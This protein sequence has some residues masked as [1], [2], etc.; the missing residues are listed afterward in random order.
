[1]RIYRARQMVERDGDGLLGF[2]SRFISAICRKDHPVSIAALST[3]RGNGKSWLA[4]YLVAKSITPGDP[5]HE[6]GIEN[7]LVASSRQ[8]AA[9][10]LNF[11]RNF[12]GEEEGYRW[13]LDGV[14]HLSSRARIRI[15]SSDSR[16]AMG[17]GA[18]V[19]LAVCDEPGSWAPQSGRRL[20]EAVTGA[21]GKR[22]MTVV[23]IGTIAPSP[24]VGP[25]SFWPDLV[26]SGSGEGRHVQL[27]AADPEKWE[28]F[29]E[30]L[31]CNPC[32]AINPY[33]KQA[34]E[35]EHQEALESPRA[36]ATF[37]KYRLNLHDGD[38]VNQQPLLTLAEWQRVCARPV[39][40]CEGNPTVG[41]DLGGTRSWSAAC[42]LW[43][44]GRIEAWA[45]APGKPSLAEQEKEDQISPDSYAEL[46]RSGGLSVDDAHAVP[47]IS[48]LLARIW[49]WEP[50]V[51]VSDPY[52]SAELHQVVNGRVRIAERAR[53]GGETTSNI[54]SLHSLLLDSDSG[55]TQESRALLEAAFMQVHLVI[56][57]SGAS[58][59]V[60]LDKRRSRD[61][62][63][64]ALLLAAGE[65][66]RRPAPVELRGAVISRE[67]LV[68]WI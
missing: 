66:A 21:I 57:N 3:P 35:R 8:Q 7:V 6:A 65:G 19:R 9:I 48:L 43:P 60:K 64:Q 34:L 53:G 46:V 5:L 50:S 26:K 67:G 14:E 40:A 36:A 17:L 44:S 68:T 4:G 22:R 38:P 25:G 10:V 31:K 30:V 55:V 18:S 59:V 12:L 2:Q 63:A 37:K 28:S 23:T 20:W 24:T 13:R 49:S 29:D 52:R 1:M 45:V 51:L 42:A 11:A 41:I 32:S 62:A 54:Q 39:P 27:L 47:D 16:R 33:L 58:K 56:D 61:D 15:I